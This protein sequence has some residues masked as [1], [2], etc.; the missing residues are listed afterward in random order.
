MAKGIVEKQKSV[1]KSKWSKAAIGAF[2]LI[3]TFSAGWGFGSGRLHVGSVG[4]VSQNKELPANLDYA[5]VEQVY[6][7][8]RANYDGKLDVNKLMDGLKQGLVAASGDPYTEYMVPDKAKDFQSELSGSFEGIGAQLGKNDNGNVI[9]VAPID[10]FPAKKAGI[11]PKDVI[12]EIDGKDATKL[13]TDQAVDKI[14][15]PKGT[16]VKL[17]IIRDQKEDLTFEI[18]RTEINIPSVENKILDGNIGYLKI[19]QFGDDTAQLSQEAANKFKQAGVK[20]VVLDLRGNPGGYLDAA[21]KVSSLW[22]QNKT[23]LE[24]K[25]DGTVVKT[26]RSQGAATLA[27]IPTTVLIDEGSAS[28]SEITA[29]AL[30]DNG[31]AKLIGTKSFGKGS[32]QQP[33]TLTNGALLKITI[34]RWYTPKGKNIDKEGIKPD[35]EV[36]ITTDDIKAG[37]DPQL[38][39]ATESLR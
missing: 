33:E 32:V 3:W 29:G 35:T 20:G 1:T 8:L 25:R 13:T 6:D 27:G 15:G 19:S 16:K 22:L 7:E 39:K 24:E 23:V 21:V 37:R 38:D 26:Y 14:R 36:Q 12:A 5:S 17:R 10:G 34:A 9:I 11:L 4:S 31:V 2:V 30:H 18:E 28:A